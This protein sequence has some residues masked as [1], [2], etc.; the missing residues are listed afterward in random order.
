MQ[1]DYWSQASIFNHVKAAKLAY[2]EFLRTFILKS[3][4]KVDKSVKDFILL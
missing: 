3:M 1:I 4:G 2:N